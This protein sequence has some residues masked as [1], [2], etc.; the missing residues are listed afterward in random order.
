[1]I[2]DLPEIIAAVIKRRREIFPEE[3]VGQKNPGDDRQRRSH[4]DPARHKDDNQRDD[5][6][7]HVTRKR[8]PGPHQQLG[9]LLPLIQRDEDRKAREYP[10]DHLSQYAALRHRDERKRQKQ[11]ETDVEGADHLA[12]KVDKVCRG[13]N[14][15]G[16]KDDRDPEQEASFEAGRKIIRERIIKIDLASALVSARGSISRHQATPVV[17]GSSGRRQKLHRP[18]IQPMRLISCPFRHSTSRRPDGPEAACR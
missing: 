15:E 17:E 3:A 1:M 6:H 8:V 5:A 18:A 12:R 11:Q 7:H 10:G 14:L 9:I 2:D 13:C 16:G 4:H